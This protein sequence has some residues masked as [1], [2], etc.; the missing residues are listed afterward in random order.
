VDSFGGTPILR[1]SPDF[2]PTATTLQHPVTILIPTALAQSSRF[3]EDLE[4]WEEWSYASRLRQAGICGL[5]CPEPLLYYNIKSGTVRS[6]SQ[7]QERAI[8]DTLKKRYPTYFKEKLMPCGS[9]PGNSQAII[10]A[11]QSFGNLPS[12]R[13][14]ATPNAD[15]RMEFVG[16]TTG[17]R[18]FNANGRVYRAGNNT[19]YRF[20]NVEKAHAEDVATLLATGMFRVVARPTTVQVQAQPQP[21]AHPQP[22]PVKIVETRPQPQPQPAPAAIAE[23][24][25]EPVEQPVEQPIEEVHQPAPPPATMRLLRA[26]LPTA[27]YEEL[28]SWSYDERLKESPRS[29]FIEEIQREIDKR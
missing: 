15:T 13:A 19:T 17:T 10:R 20:I 16:D 9:C 3:D 23:L 2:N 18:S 22:A 5:R 6:H 4:G 29:S 1:K 27:T 28:L 26:A 12:D 8:L 24:E 25:P 14:V 11:K 21:Q 7:Q